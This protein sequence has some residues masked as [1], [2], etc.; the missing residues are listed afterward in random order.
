MLDLFI[1]SV[2]PCL[3]DAADTFHQLRGGASEHELYRYVM[4]SFQAFEHAI[5]SE[6]LKR[7][8]AAVHEPSGGGGLEDEGAGDQSHRSGALQPHAIS[9]A[10][11]SVWIQGNV[12]QFGPLR[13]A[14]D[15]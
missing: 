4:Q 7:Q 12:V 1:P 10:M 15:M 5:Y 14:A 3:N 2:F 13:D 6:T 8:S 9:E 11:A